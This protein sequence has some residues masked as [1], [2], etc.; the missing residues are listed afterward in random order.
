MSPAISVYI[1]CHN[2]GRH[3]RQCVESIERQIF[4]DWELIIVDDGSEDDSWHVIEEIKRTSQSIIKT[5]KNERSVG[6]KA[7][8]NIAIRMCEGEYVMRVDADDWLTDNCLLSLHAKLTEETNS[9]ICY[10]GY[11]YVDPDGKIIGVEIPKGRIGAQFAPHGA[12]TLI[13]RRLLLE[14]GGYNETFPTQDGWDLFYR[15]NSSKPPAIV[16]SPVFYYRQHEKSLSTNIDRQLS[17][18]RALFESLA[19]S[20]LQSFSPSIEFAVSI[21]NYQKQRIELE[22]ITEKIL[23]FDSKYKNIATCL[24]I[25]S[26]MQDIS[27]VEQIISDVKPY[28]MNVYVKPRLHSPHDHVGLLSAILETLKKKSK[29][30][31]WCY[32]NLN[33]QKYEISSLYEHYNTLISTDF[34]QIISIKEERLPCFSISAFGLEII[35]MGKYRDLYQSSEMIYS[36][37]GEV[38]AGWIDDQGTKIFSSKLGYVQS[39]SVS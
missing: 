38:I 24:S 37:T 8:S 36:H 39:V 14:N 11:F 12:C 10:G 32:L 5:R 30:D 17:S 27:F 3:I 16:E 35:S 1:L 34:D 28:N 33:N 25:F 2:Y 13:Q 29:S 22:K 19:N 23:K 15:I 4:S 18:R 6:L 21:H 26:P 7:S 31:I 20:K 9:K